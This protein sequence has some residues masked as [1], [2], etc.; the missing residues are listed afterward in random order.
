MKE[1]LMV[2]KLR[3]FIENNEEFHVALLA[4]LRKTGKTTI[5][6]QLQSY[7][8]D[9]VY[10]DL[11]K[12]GDGYLEIQERFL[13]QPSSL[14]LLDEIT[15]VDHYE[16]ISQSLYDDS[17]NISKFKIVITGSSPAHIAKLAYTKL[18]GGRSKLFR[19]PLL[20]FVEYL[21]FIGKIN[22][23][24]EIDD[25]TNSDFSDYLQLKNLETSESSN[26]LWTLNNEYFQSL[27]IE[28]TIS[29]SNTY[30]SPS[31]TRLKP[32]DL[33]SL[34]DLI[35]YKLSDFCGYLNIIDP[36]VGG[37]EQINLSLVGEK[38]KLSKVDLSDV[39]VAVSS[40]MARTIRADVKGRILHHLL[41]SGLAC[42]VYTDEKVDD[43]IREDVD[44]GFVLDVLKNCTKESELITLF[45]RVTM[46]V[47][48]PL[49]YTRLG[50]DILDRAGVSRQQICASM[51][52]GMMLETY[53]CGAFCSWNN[54]LILVSRKLNY[55]GT[56]EV[57]IFDVNCRLL[58]EST[59][60]DKKSKNI[61]VSKYYKSHYLTRVCS[62]KTK[63]TF[64]GDYHQIPY[65]KLC[66][67]VDTGAVFSLEKTAI[68]DKLDVF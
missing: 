30:L 19:L 49:F 64:N 58:C 54:D 37:K 20:T 26:L 48:S 5:L 16:W 24:D 55:P 52:L 1:R 27:Y 68:F 57:D 42:I 63:E 43:P 21:Y 34:A 46:S 60:D 50:F 31:K 3:N 53:L 35:A 38:I 47:V 18:G 2:G 66:C 59:I 28:N 14:L 41:E 23:Y 32:G 6:K 13:E 44:I 61:H 22:S 17:G 4:G 56:G 9:S 33:E 7:Y 45:E 39:F 8:P 40:K 51:L 65:A 25:V 36:K 11:S 10:I 62:S 12:S 67:M 15:Y 29:N